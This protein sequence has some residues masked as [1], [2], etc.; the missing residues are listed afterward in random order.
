LL[1]SFTAAIARDPGRVCSRLVSPTLRIPSSRR[2]D[3]CDAGE[4]VP[5]HQLNRANDRALFLLNFIASVVVAI[6]LVIPLGRPPAALPSRSGE[7]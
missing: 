5:S 1:D 6:A 2:R 7:S 4:R 3:H